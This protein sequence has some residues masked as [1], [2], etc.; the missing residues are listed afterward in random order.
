LKAQLRYIL[1][2][3]TDVKLMTV[4]VEQ[5]KNFGDF[6]LNVRHGVFTA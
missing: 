6:L 2:T 3:L 1:A 5:V 4:F